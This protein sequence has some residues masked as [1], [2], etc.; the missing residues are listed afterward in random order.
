MSSGYGFNSTPPAD[1][2]EDGSVNISD[3]ILLLQSIINN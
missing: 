1:F 2:N 3:L